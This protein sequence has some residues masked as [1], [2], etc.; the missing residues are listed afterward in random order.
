MGPPQRGEVREER[1]GGYT[2]ADNGKGE[3]QLC[4]VC[5]LSDV[6]NGDEYHSRAEATAQAHYDSQPSRQLGIDVIHG[7]IGSSRG[8][9]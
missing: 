1:Y 3:Y 2:G 4:P 9:E 8:T 5:P 6:T 7:F